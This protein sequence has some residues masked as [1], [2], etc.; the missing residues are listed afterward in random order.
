MK[1]EGREME[2]KTTNCNYNFFRYYG[3]WMWF[4]ELFK[5]LEVHGGSICD[6]HLNQ[7]I[8]IPEQNCTFLATNTN[9]YFEGFLTA[10]S[11]LPGNILTIM[12]IDRIGRKI[13]LSKFLNV[14]FSQIWCKIGYV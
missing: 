5:R 6:I 9:I 1:F 11:N 12:V 10:L 7:S 2:D 14:T 13:L 3:L 4:P 8:P